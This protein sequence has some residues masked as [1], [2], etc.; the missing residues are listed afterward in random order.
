MRYVQLCAQVEVLAD[1]RQVERESRG[2][3]SSST[4]N[5]VTRNPTFARMGFDKGSHNISMSCGHLLSTT[6]AVLELD[7]TPAG[8]P[9]TPQSTAAVTADGRPTSK[10]EN[11]GD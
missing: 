8:D 6:K 4:D 7:A 1:L 11:C 5:L 10:E 2:P 9:A 3:G